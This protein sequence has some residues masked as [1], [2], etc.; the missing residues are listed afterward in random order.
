MCKSDQQVKSEGE[1]DELLLSQLKQAN[2]EKF[3][4][5]QER[6]ITPSSVGGPCP[7]PAFVGCQEFFRDFIKAAASPAFNQHLCNT[8]ASSINEVCFNAKDVNNYN[9]FLKLSI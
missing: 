3:K 1:E 6:F 9:V 5:L 8:M 2:P 7:P 4:R